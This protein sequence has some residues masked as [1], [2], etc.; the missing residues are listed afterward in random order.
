LF[1]VFNGSDR[2][3]DGESSEF[4]GNSWEFE[5]KFLEKIR[6]LMG[7]SCLEHRTSMKTSFSEPDKSNS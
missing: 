4:E 3:V 6:R 7:K 5:G 2:E 1:E